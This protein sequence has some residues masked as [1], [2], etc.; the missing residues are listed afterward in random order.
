ME[1]EVEEKP[2][3]IMLFFNK[4]LFFYKDKMPNGFASQCPLFD[5]PLIYLCHVCGRCIH[6]NVLFD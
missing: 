3:N 2:L 4:R 1:L 6:S 5:F